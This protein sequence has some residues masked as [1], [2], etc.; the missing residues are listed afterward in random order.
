M[1]SE[2]IQQ[3]KEMEWFGY[4]VQ[5]SRYM[6]SEHVIR[7][8]MVG[9]ISIADIERVLLTGNVLEERNN[10]LRG[11]SYLVFGEADGK[12]FHLVCADFRT[13]WLVVLF[14]YSPVMPVWASPIRR[15]DCG[16]VAMAESVGTCF[17]CGGT[18]LRITMGNFD[19][20][21]EGQLYV[22]KKLPA[23]LC[24]QCGEKYLQ[25]D[26]GKKLNVL[27]DE[28]KFSSSEQVFVLDYEPGED[29]L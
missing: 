1:R 16:G 25:A 8:L 27:I 12:P 15:N 3:Y 21:L 2:E 14:A 29:L 11:T 7:F 6:L 10:E 4:Q 13:G 18:L 9:K 26:V 28:K 23:T 22:V 24:Q 5:E 19:Y 20:R 17:F